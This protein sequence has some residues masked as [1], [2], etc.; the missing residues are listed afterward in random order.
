MPAA[1]TAAHVRESVSFCCSAMIA[2]AP[3]SSCPKNLKVCL[4]LLA[5]K[6][7]MHT[8]VLL[9]NKHPPSLCRLHT[10]IIFTPA[11]F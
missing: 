9:L 8:L 5:E 2:V 1:R 10:C 7:R 11:F 3:L 6:H 4:K